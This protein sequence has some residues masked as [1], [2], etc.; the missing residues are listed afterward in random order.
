MN[1]RAVNSTKEILYD[2]CE[3]LSDEGAHMFYC[4]TRK[5]NN[6]LKKGLAEIVSEN[7]I[8]FKLLFKA[9]GPGV[10]DQIP[11]ETKCV[12]CGAYQDLTRHHAVPYA[13]RRLMDRKFKDFK[14]DDVVAMCEHHHQ[15]YEVSSRELMMRMLETCSR[16][17]SDRELAKKG[18]RAVST[19]SNYKWAIPE[20]KKN[21]LKKFAKYSNME[22]L[23]DHQIV[24]SKFTPEEVISAWKGDFLKWA[25]DNGNPDFKFS[26]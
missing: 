13:F 1:P 19:L 5:A 26:K 15:R 23:S 3:C 21:M 17:I 9:K 12:V 24:L 18:K 16:E 11:K 4:S 7:P 22:I 10:P 2:N 8:I 20:E 14:S 6:Y 25:H